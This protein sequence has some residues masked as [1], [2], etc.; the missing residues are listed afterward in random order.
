MN[1]RAIALAVF[2]LWSMPAWAGMD[3]HLP[4][5]CKLGENCF[6]QNYVDHDAAAGSFHDYNCGSMTYDDHNGTDFRVKNF[7]ALD[8]HIRVLA[9]N[10]GRVKMVTYQPEIQK[11]DI[12]LLQ[13][14]KFSTR[15]ECGASIRIDHGAGWQSIYCHLD[16][17]AMAVKPADDVVTGQ[18]IGRMGASGKSIFPHLHYELR[19]HNRPVDPFV[20]HNKSYNC[21][22]HERYNLWSEKALEQLP[23]IATDI[24]FG[25]FTA[26]EPDVEKIRQRYEPP[27]FLEATNAAIYFWVELMGIRTHDVVLLTMTAPDGKMMVEKKLTYNRHFSLAFETLTA[28]RQAQYSHWP[29]GVYTVNV[30]LLRYENVWK[31]TVLS[32]DWQIELQ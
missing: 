5:E 10:N 4:V 22:P 3:L 8:S 17:K 24:I 26:K 16:P 1:I 30:T 32:R 15:S 20:G 31:Q 28:Q 23:Y 2:A 29:A 14:L 11:G 19:H 6:I 13:L 7:D 27:K 9:T 21:Q 12:P 18:V 25:G